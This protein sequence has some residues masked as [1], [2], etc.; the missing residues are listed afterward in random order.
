MRV[1]DETYTLR[2]FSCMSGHVEEVKKEKKSQVVREVKGF[3][4]HFTAA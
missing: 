2:G 3:M 4:T 1:S